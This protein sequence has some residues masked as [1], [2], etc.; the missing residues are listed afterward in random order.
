[1]PGEG[2]EISMRM[3]S[4][5]AS[6]AEIKAV[7]A[8]WTEL[9]AQEQYAAALEL[10][11]YDTMHLYEDNVWTPSLLESVVYGY[12]LAGRTKEDVLADFGCLYKITSLKDMADSEK[13]LD[14]IEIHYDFK[15]FK[16]NDIAEIWYDVPLNG[17]QS[18]LTG[19]FILRKTDGQHMM[20]VF[21]DLHVM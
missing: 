4:V 18:D 12:G 2:K 9:M 16:G 21:E 15:W 19:R 13:I 7:L 1:M 14:S 20:L 6:D 10:I 5:N 17:V 8:E 11:P 3:L